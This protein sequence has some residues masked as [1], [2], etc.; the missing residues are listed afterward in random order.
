M[1]QARLEIVMCYLHFYFNNTVFNL[2]SVA[3]QSANVLLISNIFKFICKIKFNNQSFGILRFLFAASACTHSNNFSNFLSSCFRNPCII[4]T[5]L[6]LLGFSPQSTACFPNCF[7][8]I[9]IS[10]FPNFSRIFAVPTSNPIDSFISYF[11]KLIF[12][13]FWETYLC[14]KYLRIYISYIIKMC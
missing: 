2:T 7:S 11:P 5:P 12:F 14:R 1:C 9:I 10:V 4:R 8:D 13:D 6:S 3:L